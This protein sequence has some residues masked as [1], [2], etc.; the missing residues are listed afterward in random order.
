[1]LRRRKSTQL[2]SGGAMRKG[3]G[4]N[5]WRKKKPGNQAYLA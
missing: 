5:Q 4:N 1:M 3:E 2:K